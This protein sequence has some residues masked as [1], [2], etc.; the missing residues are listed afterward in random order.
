MPQQKD[1][2][3]K[4]S[5][6]GGWSQFTTQKTKLVSDFKSAKDLS[7]NR[8]TDTDK[9][10]Y[11]EALFRGWLEQFLPA[12]Y[13]VTSGY[14]I[15]QGDSILSSDAL[16]G[17]LRHYDVIIYNRME[18]PVLWTEISP[19]H[20]EL[21]RIKAIPAEYVH[22]VLEVKSSFNA[23]NIAD[24]LKKLNELTPLLKLDAPN[25]K[26][27]RYIP[28]NFYMGLVFFN[29]A[30]KEQKKLDLLNKLKPGIFPRGFHGGIILSADG[31]DQRNTG[32]FAYLPLAGSPMYLAKPKGRTLVSEDGDI[33]SDSTE[34]SPGEHT[35]CIFGWSESNFS[36]FAFEL[37]D[38]MS[39]TYHLGTLSSQHGLRLRLG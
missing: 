37:I 31:L 26:Y 29:L 39:G 22:G 30:A 12:K 4:D 10:K 15:S 33:W 9:G 32:R 17:K 34:I 19:D 13:G 36:L 6:L 8:P 18:S 38:V 2:G 14:I 28:A 11:A 5:I 16:K 3:K 1:E 24:A 23:R 35:V 21:G 27:K 20:S 7:E 25:E